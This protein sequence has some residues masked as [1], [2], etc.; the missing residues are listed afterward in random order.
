MKTVLVKVGGSTL[1]DPGLIAELADDLVRMQSAHP[2]VVHG[3]GKDISRALDRLGKPTEFVDGLRVTDAEAMET[4]EM[5]LSAQVNKRLVRAVIAEGGRAVGLSG[6]D[7]ALFRAKPYGDGRL[8]FVGQID[9]VNPTIIHALIND[10]FLPIVSPISLGTDGL[11]YN[12][13]ADHAAAD[14]AMALP[15]D[16]LLF[17]TDVPG[18]LVEGLPVPELSVADAENLIAAGQITGGMIPK[19]RSCAEAVLR[20]VKR[21]H[22]LAWQGP[23][24]I[25]EHLGGHQRHGTVIER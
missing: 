11:P 4:V 21:V 3:G 5:V 25:S 1:D 20:G 19:V 2:I 22:V 16:D 17:I 14:L 13:N 9:A 24:T 23:K 6:I 8:G 10:G 12:V 18:V 15:V 7:S